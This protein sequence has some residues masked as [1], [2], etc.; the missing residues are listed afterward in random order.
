MTELVLIVDA[1]AADGGPAALLSAGQDVPLRRLLAGTAPFG[2]TP[3][4]VLTRRAWLEEVSAAASGE[5]TA[6]PYEGRAGAL[7]SLAAQLD[8]LRGP[9][10]LAHGEVLT[11]ADALG[12]VV[13]DSRLGTAV[14]VGPTT[15]GAL[16][17]VSEGRVIAAGSA[18]HRISGAGHV[19]LGVLLVSETD[20]PVLAAAAR[21]LA[22]LAMVRGWEA[23]VLDLLVLAAVRRGLVVSA[24]PIGAYPW[25]RPATADQ[26]LRVAERLDSL[27]ARKVRL[28]R[29]ARPDDGFYSTFVVRKLSRRVTGW[30]VHTSLTPNAITLIALVVALIAAGAFATGERAGLIAGALLLQVSLVIDCVDGEVARYTRTFSALGAWL[31]LTTDRIKEYACYAALAVGAARAD[32]SAWTLAA[33][34]LALQVFRNFV[35]FGFV[36]TV[37]ARKAALRGE[38]LPLDQVGDPTAGPVSGDAGGSAGAGES[39]R[40]VAALGQGAVALSNRTSG[41]APLKWAKRMVFLPIGE[42]W[43]IISVFAAASG[44]RAVFWV[45]FGLGLV[46]AVYATAGRVLRALAD[47]PPEAADEDRAAA[48]VPA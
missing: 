41:S 37:L 12:D 11:A 36:T 8:R 13:A 22:G 28:E 14:L 31:D 38:M 6:V 18:D 5:V 47:P 39:A 25:A 15:D 43:L 26:A 4:V 45:L 19:G 32:D 20:R 33:A 44:P 17:R 7:A 24:V 3:A 9:V 2:V 23:D 42:R 40:A 34:T 10:V 35:D 1:S 48:S 27:D 46:S 29:V 30:A 16:L 21:E